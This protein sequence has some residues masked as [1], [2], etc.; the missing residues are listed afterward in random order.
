MTNPIDVKAYSM[1]YTFLSNVA[2]KSCVPPQTFVVYAC[3]STQCTN[4]MKV[5]APFLKGTHPIVMT[6]GDYEE[7]ELQVYNVESK[8]SSVIYT[9]GEPYQYKHR[10]TFKVTFQGHKGFRWIVIAVASPKSQTKSLSQHAQCMCSHVNSV[11]IDS[12]Q[13][14]VS[15][16]SYT[17]KDKTWALDD[18]HLSA[19][20]YLGYLDGS[21]GKLGARVYSIYAPLPTLTSFMQTIINDTR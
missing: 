9:F 6:G 21:D 18:M 15:D 12:L 1:L 11:L 10:P 19:S 14:N 16:D 20:S 8:Y 13:Y 7:G 3:E 4:D 5:T 17:Y 2:D